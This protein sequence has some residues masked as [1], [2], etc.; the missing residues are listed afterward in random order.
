[1]SE[2]GWSVLPKA[3]VPTS[4]SCARGNLE[5]LL[6]GLG[7][8]AGIGVLRWASSEPPQVFDL[9]DAYSGIFTTGAFDPS[10][11]AS[12]AASFA[13]CRILSRFG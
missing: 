13:A 4:G 12:R 3:A 6:L 10:F 1:M 5:R 9:G 7:V 11:R 2:S 8:I